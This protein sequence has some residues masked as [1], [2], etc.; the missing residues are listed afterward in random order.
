M[1]VF[2]KDPETEFR[3]QIEDM[4]LPC[5]AEVIGFDRLKRDFHQF[6]DKRNLLKDYD[7]F[8]ADIRIYKMLP[9]MLGKEFYSK[10][11]FPCPIK[12]H[13]LSSGAELEKQLNQAAGDAYYIQGNGPNYSCKIGK[14]NMDSKDIAKNA[15]QAL[16]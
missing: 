12:L 2:V 6:A 16:G 4:K 7:L 11:A 14:V 15:E 13:G 3:Q 9:E 1:C 5:I 8:L 10:K